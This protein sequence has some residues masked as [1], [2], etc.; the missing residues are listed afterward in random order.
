[1]PKISTKSKE[2]QT[3]SRKINLKIKQKHNHL[4]S[5][6]PEIVGKAN[7]SR[8]LTSEWT[9]KQ[10]SPITQIDYRSQRKKNSD[11]I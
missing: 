4:Q 9:N 5:S 3:Q 10:T 8:A 2:K 11:G 1:M 6:K 7:E